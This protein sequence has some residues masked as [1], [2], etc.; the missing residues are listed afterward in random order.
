MAC[1]LLS[2]LAKSDAIKMLFSMRRK[3]LADISQSE[4]PMNQLMDCFVQG[5]EK[6]LNQYAN[7]DFLANLFSDLTRF[8]EGRTYFLSQQKYDDV[9]PIS[10]LVV[11]TEGT[12]Q[13]RRTGVASVIK[14]CCFETAKHDYLLDP[15]AINILPYLLLPLC[16]PEEFPEDENENMP[17]ELQLLEPDKKRETD[18]FTITIHADAL[19][20]LCTTR[21]G[22]MY[23]RDKNVYP[24]IRQLHLAVEHEDVGECCDKLVN[25]LMRDEAPEGEETNDNGVY[26]NEDED[27][28]DGKITTI[29]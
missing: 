1:M 6:K 3:T 16:G 14:N 10:K 22:R 18:P 17:E 12:S 5:A 28:D 29:L 7:Y 13:V 20:L 25:V 24:I 19:L 26:C 21:K 15:D 8:P 23:L 4:D 2:N 27:S 9:V 11:F